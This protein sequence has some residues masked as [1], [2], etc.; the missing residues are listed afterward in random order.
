MANT[1]TKADLPGHQMAKKIAEMLNPAKVTG[2][3]ISAI[4]KYV[5]GVNTISMGI[6]GFIDWFAGTSLVQKL[7][8]WSGAL[9]SLEAL[10]VL[11]G[12]VSPRLY[13]FNW[14]IS[15]KEIQDQLKNSLNNLYGQLGESV[16]QSVG[17]LICGVV[18]ATLT[19]AYNP[20]VAAIV[21]QNLTQEA[22]E[23]VWGSI[24]SCQQSSVALLGNALVLQGFKSSRRWLKRPNTPMYNLLKQHFGASFENW[25]KDNQPSWSMSSYIENKIEQIKD[26]GWR[27]FVEEFVDG[28]QDGC[29]EAIQ[30][31]KNNMAQAMAAYAAV[32]RHENSQQSRQMVVEL[33]FSRDETPPATP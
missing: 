10:F 21:M 12:G 30:S 1:I 8:K 15:D 6:A 7:L 2:Q 14:N 16:G 24:A 9:P 3:L 31:W 4:I 18:P 13:N 32:R 29:S 28:F 25:G 23:E 17:W 20:G 19:F 5:P 22:Q 27:N 26:P 11:I 33:D